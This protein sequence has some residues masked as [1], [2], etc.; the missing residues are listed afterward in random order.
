MADIAGYDTEPLGG[1][2]SLAGADSALRQRGAPGRRKSHAIELF[3]LGELM[4]GPHHG[5]LLRDILSR[6]L[7]PYRQISWAAIYPLLHQLEEDAL[8]EPLPAAPA[9]PAAAPGAPGARGEEPSTGRQRRVVRI[10]AAGRQRLLALMLAHGAHTTEYHDLF[11]IKLLYLRHLPPHQQQAILEHG[12]GYLQRQST[13]LR[14]VFTAQSTSAYL[15]AEQRQ[16]IVR[17]MRFRLASVE[18]EARWVTDE[19]VRLKEPTTTLTAP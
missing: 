3:I 10:T 13:H 6:M 8:I 9:T 5:Y 19:L 14:H 15:P 1:S 12:L 7:G 11:T 18:A 2:D 17:M 4:D 16:A